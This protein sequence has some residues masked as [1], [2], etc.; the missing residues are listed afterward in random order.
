MTVRFAALEAARIEADLAGATFIVAR[1]F[2]G[3]R[4][5]FFA[6]SSFTCEAVFAGAAFVASGRAALVDAYPSWAT[7]GVEL[8]NIFICAAFAVDTELTVGAA[9]GLGAAHRRFD[10]R[11]AKTVQAYQALITVCV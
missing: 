9:A 4:L 6:E 3:W 2:T 11:G 8:A 10:G 5:D 7:L 1:T